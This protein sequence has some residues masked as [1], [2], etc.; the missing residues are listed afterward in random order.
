MNNII[1]YQE[2]QDS[3]LP[4]TS[5]LAESSINSIINER[6]KNKKMQWTR[7]GAHNILQIRTSMFSKGFDADWSIIPGKMYKKAA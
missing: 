6:Q 4:F 5:Q 7:V 1:N 3:K 2:R